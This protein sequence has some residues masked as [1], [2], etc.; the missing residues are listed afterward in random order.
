MNRFF[1]GFLLVIFSV[2]SHAE[3]ILATS[4]TSSGPSYGFN[5]QINGSPTLYAGLQSALD[6][7]NSSVGHTPKN[8]FYGTVSVE[9]VGLNYIC[10]AIGENFYINHSTSCYNG[11]TYTSSGCTAGYSCPVNQNWTLSGT[12]CTRPDCVSPETR[13]S[14]G[15]CAVPCPAAGSSVSGVTGKYFNVLDVPTSG[16][17]IS[18]CTYAWG[19]TGGRSGGSNLW[20]VNAGTSMG[21][22]CLPGVGGI[23]AALPADSNTNTCAAKN[24]CGGVLNMV[25]VC[26][27]CAK[28]SVQSTSTATKTNPDGTTGSTSTT[29]ITNCDALGT[30]STHTTQ[31]NAGGGTQASAGSTAPT[32]TTTLDSS[33]DKVSFCAT[34]PTNPACAQPSDC[35][36]NPDLP[37]CKSLGTPDAESALPSTS[38]SISNLTPV[39]LPGAAVCPANVPLPHGAYFDWTPACTYASALRPLVLI[40]AWL[41]A[42]LIL[43]GVVRG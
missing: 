27:A 33:M 29:S 7:L 31:N 24:L 3:T 1:I 40:M 26:T 37:Q 28:T 39:D 9:A 2:F 22:H 18:G 17:C 36:K 10:H 13:Q 35:D 43:V 14:D 12:S 6:F 25:E 41:A 19:G 20:A 15:T 42:G 23:S 8:C 21:A 32:G 4:T 5:Y 34:N 38:I 11:G 16:M 30:C